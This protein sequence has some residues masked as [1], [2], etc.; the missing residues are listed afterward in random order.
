MG[1][2]SDLLTVPSR[3]NLPEAEFSLLVRP[4]EVKR[5]GGYRDCCH[6]CMVGL[7]PDNTLK[8]VVK[9]KPDPAYAKNYYSTIHTGVI[10]TCHNTYR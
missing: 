4:R 7:Y 3:L 1:E 6:E 2:R 5:P 9:G 8:Y 10:K